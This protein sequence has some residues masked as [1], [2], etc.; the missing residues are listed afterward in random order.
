M[1]ALVERLYPICRSLTGPG[2][3]QTLAIIGESVDLAL[4]ELPSGTEVF[5][6]VIPDEWTP[7]SAEIVGPDGVARA[8][9]KDHNLHLLGCSVP[10][11]REMDLAELLEHIY[12]LPDEPDLIPYVVSYYKRDWGFAMKDREKRA[13]PPGRYR[14]RIDTTLE[15]GSMT[16]G[17]AVLPGRTDREVLI[18]TYVC[19]PSMA[20]DN[21]SGI[22][23]AAALYRL[24]ASMPDRH[25]SYRF[26]WIPET[27]GAIAWLSLNQDHAKQKMTAGMVFSCVGD[28]GP[29]TWKLSRRGDAEIDRIARLVLARSGLDHRVTPFLPAK[30]SDERQFGSPGFNLP[31]GLLSRSVPGEFRSY[32]TSGDTPELVTADG[33]AGSLKAAYEMIETLESNS[34]RYKRIDPHCEP[35]LT[36]KRLIQSVS[37]R[38]RP[39]YDMTA[40]PLVALRWVLN[41]C[42]GEHGLLDIAELSDVPMPA[43]ASAAQRAHQA[44]LLTIV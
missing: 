10:V 40:D 2:N 24:V 19:H 7:R 20:N 41:Y 18:S 42:D 26:I 22:A 9:F 43:L 25:Y 35:M 29:L 5:D 36:N 44:G 39:G 11:D 28:E 32:H 6:W 34:I 23:V 14:V 12:T 38:N 27:I 37:I 3:R 8:R 21:L 4:T 17:E 31:V 13:L 1:Q 16:F 33:H 30:G 15:P